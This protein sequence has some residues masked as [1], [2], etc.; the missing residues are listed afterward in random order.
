MAG[1]ADPQAIV[2]IQ[3]VTEHLEDADTRLVLADRHFNTAE[4]PRIPGSVVWRWREHMQQPGIHD[5]PDKSMMEDLLARSGIG[6]DTT[7]V[8]YGRANNWYAAYAFWLL[9]IYGHQDVRLMHGGI[10][11]WSAAGHATTTEE[12]KITGTSYQAREPDWS[13]RALSAE[14]RD[15]LDDDNCMLVDVRSPPEYAGEVFA[16]QTP[17]KFGERAGRIPGAVHIPCPLTENEDGT[18]KTEAELRSLFEG[19]GVT[20]DKEAI[21]Y[22][23]IGARSANTWF[24]L[25]HLLGYPNARL[26]DGSWGEWGNL[27]G[28][29]IE[30]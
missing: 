13:T 28:V 26:Y 18:Y 29:P 17:V 27:M 10:K 11:Q 24:A 15:A 5:I 9:K 7:V 30:T 21:V 19:K 25:K 1:Y 23:T 12:P 6:N 2:D 4:D 8:L 16:P 20:P 3:W 14:V 22:C